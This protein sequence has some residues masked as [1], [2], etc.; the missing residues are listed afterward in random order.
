MYSVIVLLV[1]VLAYIYIYISP[2]FILTRMMFISIVYFFGVGYRW[3]PFIY[4]FFYYYLFINCLLVRNHVDLLIT[5][6]LFLT[7]V[8]FISFVYGG[9]M[10]S[11]I[12]FCFHWDLCLFLCFT[13]A[14]LSIKNCYCHLWRHN[15][16]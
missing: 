12:I 10:L 6:L 7:R 3:V 4:L 9:V 14:I 5:F 1:G 11:S 8:M 16:Q 13:V 15:L 2:L